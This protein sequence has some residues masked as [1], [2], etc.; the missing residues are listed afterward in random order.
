ME[1][2][3]PIQR[4]RSPATTARAR[5]TQQWLHWGD[6]CS[7]RPKARHRRCCCRQPRQFPAPSAK[8]NAAPL[9]HFTSTISNRPSRCSS[10]SISPWRQRQRC[11]STC[12]PCPTSTVAT[13]RSAASPRSAAESMVFT[14]T[15]LRLPLPWCPRTEILT[16]P[17]TVLKPSYGV[18]HQGEDNKRLNSARCWSLLR[19]APEFAIGSGSFHGG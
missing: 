14:H 15:V 1:S 2:P 18:D 13:R 6:A 16:L 8:A 11:S 7:Q 4:I 17:W 12:Q 3:R 19:H 5:A 10:R 9:R